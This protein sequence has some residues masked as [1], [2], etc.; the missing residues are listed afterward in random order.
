MNGQGRFRRE[1]RKLR[2]LVALGLLALILFLVDR[3]LPGPDPW[4]LPPEVAGRIRNAIDTVFTRHGID[5][6]GVRTW[7]AQGQNGRLPRVEQ[8]AKVP[9][10]FPSLLVNHEL[11]R[12]LEPVGGHIVAIERTKDNTVT[13]H[14]VRQGVTI[15]SI[16]F[17]VDPKM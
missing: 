12:L 4:I 3:V 17:H 1:T 16:A 11:A 7:N 6:S 5:P 15:R 8:R 2:V 13:M 14:I 9:P 10:G